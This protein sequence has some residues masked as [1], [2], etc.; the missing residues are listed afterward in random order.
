VLTYRTY[1]GARLDLQFY[2]GK[3]SIDY[4]IEVFND[5]T[6]TTEADLSGYASFHFDIFHKKYGTLVLSLS[7]AEGEI[8]F[9]SPETNILYLDVSHVKTDLR[10]KE[11]W[12]ECFGIV[13][14]GEEELIFYGVAEVI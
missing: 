4:P 8:W 14:D 5:D 3:A 9:G 2:K 10:V 12:Y 11:Y 6:L 13:D 7:E 1:R